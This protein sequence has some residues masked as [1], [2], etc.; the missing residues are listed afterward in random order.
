MKP[1]LKILIV[2]V[3]VGLIGLGVYFVFKPQPLVIEDVP[4]TSGLP[5]GELP[6]SG[7]QTSGEPTSGEPTPPGTETPTSKEKVL[8]VLSD[9]QVSDFWVAGGEVYY[10]NLSGKIYKAKINED[11]E[12]S[13]QTLNGPINKIESDEWGNLVLISFGSPLSP[14]WTVFDSRDAAF[15]PLAQDIKLAA[16][17]NKSAEI[18]AVK[19]LP[20]GTRQLVFLDA[21]KLSAAPKIILNDFRMESIQIT[22]GGGDNFLIQELPDSEYG[23]RV[24]I[25][26]TKNQTLITLRDSASNQVIKR[27]SSNAFFV[28]SGGNSFE[29]AKNANLTESFP[30]PFSTLPQKCGAKTYDTFCFVPQNLGEDAMSKF[31]KNEIFFRDTLY[32]IIP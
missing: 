1:W 17:G 29:I 11:E 20:N 23:G 7:G 26:N 8:S 4:G 25:F 22:A 27:G 5:V 10:V 19:E 21:D 6:T 30:V 3:V 28:W 2:A 14:S 12:V 31:L 18:I 15:R 32:K 13:N 9:Q 16:W 24:W